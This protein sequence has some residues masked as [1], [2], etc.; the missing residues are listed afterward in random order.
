M[1]GPTGGSKKENLKLYETI[2]I[3]ELEGLLIIIL[4]ER[5]Q[6]KISGGASLNPNIP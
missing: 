2:R 1:L 4:E 5:E 6:E 3:Q